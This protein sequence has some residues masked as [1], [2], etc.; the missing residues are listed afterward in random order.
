MS[1]TAID[2]RIVFVCANGEQ[3]IA[4]EVQDH[5]AALKGAQL[6]NRARYL[7]DVKRKYTAS[8]RLFAEAE[9]LAGFR[10]VQS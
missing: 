7:N 3:N 1:Y 2:S 4:A 8:A 10:W 9:Q 5:A 6:M